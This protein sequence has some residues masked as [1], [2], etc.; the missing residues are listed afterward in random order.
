MRIQGNP[1]GLLSGVINPD[2]PPTARTSQGACHIAFTDS[3]RKNLRW[4]KGFRARGAPSTAL[5]GFHVVKFASSAKMHQFHHSPVPP[6]P[7][8]RPLSPHRGIRSGISD[9]LFGVL[10]APHGAGRQRRSLGT[11][12]WGSNTMQERG[13]LDPYRAPRGGVP[14]ASSVLSRAR[15]TGLRGAPPGLPRPLPPRDH[16]CSISVISRSG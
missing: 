8:L 14:E 9:Q 3:R 2:R 10:E 5:P 13:Y 1:A 4:D 16:R 6:C 15:R 12:S 7:R 11:R